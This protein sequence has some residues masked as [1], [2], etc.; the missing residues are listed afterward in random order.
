M[1][2]LNSKKYDYQINKILEASTLDI[3]WKGII[4]A[5]SELS[6]AEKLKA[7]GCLNQAWSNAMFIEMIDEV[8]G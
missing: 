5:H 2:R 6:S 4:G 7:E 8:V 3:L 1:L